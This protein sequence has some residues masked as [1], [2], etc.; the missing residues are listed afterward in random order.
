MF[1]TMD[2][3]HPQ[4]WGERWRGRNVSSWR[5]GPEGRLERLA[6]YASL[7]DGVVFVL[8]GDEA[9]ARAEA[10]LARTRPPRPVLGAFGGYGPNF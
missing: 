10:Y 8:R 3:L 4:V 9:D 5:P 1:L 6:W 7:P 2:V